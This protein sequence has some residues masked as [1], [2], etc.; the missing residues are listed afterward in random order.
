MLR[1]V[2]ALVLVL[3]TVSVLQ[4]P[5]SASPEPVPKAAAD[6]DPLLRIALPGEPLQFDPQ[7]A[8][9]AADAA[10][11]RLV[12]EP[13][14]RFD[15]HL[16][17]QP[18]AAES[19]LVSE[20]GTRWTFKLRPHV[21][22]SDGER[23]S[24]REFLFAWRRLLS[25]EVPEDLFQHFRPIVGAG[26]FRA[27][28]LDDPDRVG[29]RAPDDDTFEVRLERPSPHLLSLASL[30]LTAPVR[31]DIVEG[32]P[33]WARSPETVIGNG[34][35]VLLEASAGELR[36]GPNRH[37][38]EGAPRI[39]L[40]YLVRGSDEAAYQTFLAGEADV[41]GVP[42]AR[43]AEVVA[44]SAL[45]PLVARGPRPAALWLNLNAKRVPFDSPLVRKAFAYALDR[46]AFV[47]EVLGGAGQ[48]AYSLV[49]AALPGHE[50]DLGLAYRLNP[51]AAATLLEVAGHQARDFPA[52]TLRHPRGARPERAAVFVRDQLQR[53]AGIAIRLEA[54]DPFAFAYALEERQYDLALTGWESA[55]PD[56]EH[57]FWLTFGA[58]KVE[59]RT[60]W[61]SR[62]FDDLWRAAEE[63]IPLAE[64]LP[65]YRAAQQVLV[66]EMPV[67]WL[68]HLEKLALIRP[69]VRG[70][71]LGAMDEVPGI[72][73][74]ATVTLADR[75]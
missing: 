6:E 25:R 52:V 13:L 21:R 44:D 50:P 63:R 37:Y 18:A 30:W 51:V 9:T 38:W 53:H 22:W 72:S 35:F 58:D 64:R 32:R 7:R 17:P 28:L 41:A 29:L 62:A 43:A 19:F 54:L 56:P 70:L 57:W 11:I 23:V 24:A 45:R 26:A 10:V 8:T 12:F 15:H 71:R 40:R 1:K 27:G 69:R 75:T 60:G 55:Y 61:S 66:D 48:S 49:P 16:T 39:A 3:A 20:D 68:A 47:R 33:G 46:D 67:V 5:A 14:F 36:F 65:L 31:R 4:G 34:P 59:N 74:Y 2:S 73:S 42:D